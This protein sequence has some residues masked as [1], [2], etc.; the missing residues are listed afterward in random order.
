MGN[1]IN[2]R[3]ETTDASSHSAPRTRIVSSDREFSSATPRRFN[4]RLASARDRIR[5]RDR[6]Q[7]ERVRVERMLAA[8]PTPLESAAQW[9]ALQNLPSQGRTP[10]G[11]S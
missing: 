11:V 8:A 7:Q 1:D 3:R 2:R 5:L 4:A 6:N 10:N 9:D